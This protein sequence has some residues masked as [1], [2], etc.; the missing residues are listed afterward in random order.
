[1]NYVCFQVCQSL[2]LH[3]FL[4]LPMQRI[5]RLPLL[6]AAILSHCGAISD[7]DQENNLVFSEKE[8]FQ[9]CL[10][11]LN[12]LVTRWEIEWVVSV[13][14]CDWSVEPSCQKCIG[15]LTFFIRTWTTLLMIC[16]Q[17]V[18]RGRDIARDKT[19]LSRLATIWIS[20]RCQN[21]ITALLL[22]S[23]FMLLHA[24]ENYI[25]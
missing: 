22:V 19:S 18:M 17:G 24:P 3:S 21:V 1:M 23:I 7:Q 16:W 25:F 9:K 15:C 10:E 8:T 4:M 5:T 2:S 6:T 14:T 11:T 12:D 13:Y 20:S